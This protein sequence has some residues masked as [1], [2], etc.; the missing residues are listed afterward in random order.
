MYV[1]IC[2][3][4]SDTEIDDAIQAGA[5]CPDSLAARTGAST[6]C[7]MCRETLCERLAGKLSTAA[8]VA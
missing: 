4:I 7:G 3:G 1:C 2:H 8:V 5:H 6:G